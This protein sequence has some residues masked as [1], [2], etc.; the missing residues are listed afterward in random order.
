MVF[1]VKK[2]VKNIIYEV[3]PKGTNHPFADVKY[4]S[5]KHRAR[6]FVKNNKKPLQLRKVLSPGISTR[7][8]E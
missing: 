4:F 5:N 8:L 1:E 6:K 3:S 2:M 7:D